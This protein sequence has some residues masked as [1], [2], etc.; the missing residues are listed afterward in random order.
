MLALPIASEEEDGRI[1]ALYASRL[2]DNYPASAEVFDGIAAEA[3]APAHRRPRL[4]MPVRCVSVVPRLS[5]CPRTRQAA[6]SRAFAS[7]RY[8]SRVR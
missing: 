1:Y 8:F 3:A 2:R 4:R 5:T 7:P 6:A